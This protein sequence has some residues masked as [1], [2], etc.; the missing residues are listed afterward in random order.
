MSKQELFEQIEK[1]FEEFKTAH[2][3]TKKKDGAVARKAIGNLKKLA[4]P[5]NKA[6]VSEAKLVKA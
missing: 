2:H 3:S 6:S 5:Y 1:Y 4:T